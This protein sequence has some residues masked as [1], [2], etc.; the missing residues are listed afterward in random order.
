MWK[1]IRWKCYGQQ[2]N[3]GH[4]RCIPIPTTNVRTTMHFAY[5]SERVNILRTLWPSSFDR[6]T[7]LHY[8]CIC[9][10]L[11]K[12]YSWRLSY[13]SL[14]SSYARWKRKNK[15]NKY[16]RL[17]MHM[18]VCYGQVR[19]EMHI[20]T[21]HEPLGHLRIVNSARFDWL[22]I[23]CL[24]IW[25][26]SDASMKYGEKSAQT[27]NYLTCYCFHIFFSPI[28]SHAIT[29][30]VTVAGVRVCEW[31]PCA[32]PMQLLCL[33]FVRSRNDQRNKLKWEAII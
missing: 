25:I 18:N 31:V 26:A 14:S 7:L 28:Q 3:G 27:G 22:T 19:T 29:R 24:R 17:C 16:R 15:I 6:N 9:S 10:M 1:F 2:T 20:A 30:N 4:C 33:Q 21:H 32:V 11:M 12:R 5:Y 8:C 13:K 23:L